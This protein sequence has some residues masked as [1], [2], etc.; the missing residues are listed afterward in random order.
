MSCVLCRVC[1]VVFA[2]VWP[3]M[4]QRENMELP[5]DLMKTKLCPPLR[6]LVSSCVVSSPLCVVASNLVYVIFTRRL[7]SSGIFRRLSSRALHWCV[8]C[9]CHVSRRRV[10]SCTS[11]SL[12]VCS[13]RILSC[14]ALLNVAL[15]II[16]SRRWKASRLKA[17][18]W[19]FIHCRASRRS[20]THALFLCAQAW[21]SP[22]HS[23]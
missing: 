12:S 5:S 6:P 8:R 15:E 19:H 4:M 7:S 13:R 3:V 23:P 17:L 14:A 20:G 16:E 21:T 22:C 10:C 11:V 2:R 1:S 18:V 9:G